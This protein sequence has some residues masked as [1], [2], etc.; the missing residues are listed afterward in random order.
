MQM[1][2]LTSYCFYNKYTRIA[3]LLNISKNFALIVHVF[4]LY[5]IIITHMQANESKITFAAV[6]H[7][8][9]NALIAPFF[10]R[11]NTFSCSFNSRHDRLILG[12]YNL[13][14]AFA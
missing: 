11:T 12:K 6:I 5:T 2:A 14:S 8:L 4:L 13:P 10:L 3:L 9:Q 7:G 1:Q